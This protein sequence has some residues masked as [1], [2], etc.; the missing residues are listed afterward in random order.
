MLEF[1]LAAKES[2]EMVF[3]GSIQCEVWFSQEKVGSFA[4]EKKTKD[5]YSTLCAWADQYHGEIYMGDKPSL[6]N[7]VLS[8]EMEVKEPQSFLLISNI[9]WDID[10]DSLF[11][12]DEAEWSIADQFI[13]SLE[14]LR[15]KEQVEVCYLSI[16]QPNSEG[17]KWDKV[18]KGLGF[19]V[20]SK[21][22]FETFYVSTYHLCAECCEWIKVSEKLCRTCEYQ[23]QMDEMTI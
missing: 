9:Q 21:T 11:R 4:Y 22:N 14:Y 8:S 12:E 18:V 7:L 6:L 15:E 16:E 23:Y 10:N 3:E 17:S 1:K 19:E 2:E 20:A 5:Q 13:S